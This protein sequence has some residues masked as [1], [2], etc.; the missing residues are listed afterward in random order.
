MS[1]N[2]GAGSSSSDP[3]GRVVVM[4]TAEARTAAQE[5]FLAKLKEG[6]PIDAAGE[7]VGVTVKT[8]YVW[9]R[10]DESFRNRWNEAY[11][12]GTGE[13]RRQGFQGSPRGLRIA[14]AQTF[15]VP[16]DCPP[17][18][19]PQCTDPDCDVPPGTCHCDCGLPVPIADQSDTK[20]GCVKGKPVLY[21][22]GHNRSGHTLMAASD[23]EPLIAA[24]ARVNVSRQALSLRAGLGKGTLGEVIDI[25]GYRLHQR[26]CERVVGELRQEYERFGLDPAEVT[27]ERLFTA[28]R[29]RA[30]T[31]GARRR[32][33]R[34]RRRPSI[35]PVE[36]GDGRHFKEAARRAE[37]LVPGGINEARGAREIL[38]MNT[39]QLGGLRKRGLV[40][41]ALVDAGPLRMTIY[42]EGELKR[43]ARELLRDRDPR[44]VRCRDRGEHFAQLIARGIPKDRA[45]ELVN[46]HQG[47]LERWSR[48]RIGTGRRKSAG[49][50]AHHV[51]WEQA[52]AELKA[53]LEAN[54]E[55]HHVDGDRSPSDWEVAL[56]VAGDDFQTHPQRWKYDPSENRNEGA[57]RVLT[58]VKRLQSAQ[59]RTRAA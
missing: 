9:R 26:R 39:N 52:F 53:E 43:L 40:E 29:P 32:R 47:A 15:S 28:A 36:R 11:A 7:D 42:T 50:A 22:V 34:E 4:L 23:G 55:A 10:E 33:P 37:A 59:T 54:Y 24:L 20:R 58:A 2:L 3:L 30:E 38:G 45:R 6:A 25:E 8:L 19:C 12:A 41:P 14:A 13:L 56:L 44:R 18:G 5:S 1:A 35:P 16:E 17:C 46:R 51:E 21:A 31:P 27:L 49:P 57:T 48:I